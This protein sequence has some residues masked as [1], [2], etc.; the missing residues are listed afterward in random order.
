MSRVNFFSGYSYLKGLFKK[1]KLAQFNE[2]K[3]LFKPEIKSYDELI[4]LVNMI[5]EN[6]S[7]KI[8][9]K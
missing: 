2:Y 7:S 8:E 9:I 4:E 5:F 6:R 1:N 3:I